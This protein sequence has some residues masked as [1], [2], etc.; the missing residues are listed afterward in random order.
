MRLLYPLATL[1]VLWGCAS[2]KAS[3]QGIADTATVSRIV[4]TLAADDMEGRASF[5]PGIERAAEFIIGEFERIGL[6]HHTDGS[7]RQTFNVT[8]IQ[9]ASTEVVLDGTVAED[10]RVIVSSTNPGIAWND[11]PGVAI[12]EIKAGED[13]ASRFRELSNG[14]QD[15]LVRVDTSFSSLFGRYKRFVSNPRV[16]G[17]APASAASVVY[18]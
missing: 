13:F 6:E 9:P 11:D 4:H 17:E 14:G 10:D 2:R 12:L 3:H 5:T 1:L 15:A 7:F 18:V 16:L 8:R